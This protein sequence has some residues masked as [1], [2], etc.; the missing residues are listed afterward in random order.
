MDGNRDHGSRYAIQMPHETVVKGDSRSASIAAASILA[1]V[2]R[3]RYME[4]MAQRYPQYEFQRHKGYPTKLHYEL[5][6]EYGPCPIHR[7]SLFEKAVKGGGEARRLGRWG[8]AAGGAATCE[9]KGWTVLARNYRCRFGEMDLD[10]AEGRGA[11]P[12]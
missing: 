5:L 1:K 10:G 4:E 7:R 12:L 3:D 6:R 11:W 2:S 9:R 8:E